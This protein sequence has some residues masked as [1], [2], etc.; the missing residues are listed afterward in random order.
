MKFSYSSAWEE[1]V[2]LIKSHFPL[3]LA[4]AGVFLFLPSL[5][6]GHFFPMSSPGNAT[7]QQ[8]VDA[9]REYVSANGH[10]LFL[11]G[12]LNMVGALAM[13]ILIFD[14]ARPTVGSAI[15][16]A[17]AILP[18]YFLASLLS[19]LIMLGGFLLFIIPAFYLYGRLAVLAPVMVVEGQRN[20]V[21]AI[22]RSFAVT[23][24]NGW[25]VLGLI[26][27]VAVAG[28]LISTA[29]VVVLGSVFVI[30]LGQQLGLLLA[31]IL[32]TAI[33]TSVST[34]VIA[35]T[36]TIYRQLAAKASAAD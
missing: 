28:I 31:L 26:L 5:L 12:L 34:L 32:K 35:L 16:R 20:P 13:L 10:W 15:G 27:A 2:G 1:A 17:F 4:I 7:F 23:R 21:V 6:V 19:G 18:F 22:Q 14:S 8:L 25:A 30:L 11:N 9:F 24:G 33:D 3:F 36:A 29:I